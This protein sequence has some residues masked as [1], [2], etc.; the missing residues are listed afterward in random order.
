MSEKAFF[1][2]GQMNKNSL[3]CHDA[4]ISLYREEAMKSFYTSSIKKL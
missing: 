3:C 2:Y 4:L 1:F